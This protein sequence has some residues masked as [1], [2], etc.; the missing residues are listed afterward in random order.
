MVREL[1]VLS[2]TDQFTF[3]RTI[4]VTPNRHGGDEFSADNLL[5]ENPDNSVEFDRHFQEDLSAQQPVSKQPLGD[6]QTK[7]SSA[8]RKINQHNSSSHLS[9]HN[10]PISISD[11]WY[12]TDFQT[13]NHSLAIPEIIIPPLEN[14]DP[15]TQPK[16]HRYLDRILVAAAIGYCGF[17]GW[18]LFGSQNSIF[19]SNLLRNNQ[20]TISQADLDFLEYFEQ[21]LAVI[22]SNPNQDRNSTNNQ[23]TNKNKKEDVVYLPVYTPTPPA[24]SNH[25]NFALQP[26]SL[27]PPPP[28]PNN[29]AAFNPPVSTSPIKKPAPPTRSSAS[30]S[31][32]TSNPNNVSIASSKLPVIEN[33]PQAKVQQ[34]APPQLNQPTL[35][36]IIELKA[37]SAALF[38][39][40]GN[41]EKIWLGDKIG[42]T[43]WQLVSINNQKAKISNQKNNLVLGIGQSF[44]AAN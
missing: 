26:N 19:A 40:N 16:S 22:D 42:N 38:K 41:T 4:R 17:L 10:H 21:S 3:I 13:P 32:K 36:G 12:Q 43:G 7:D 15:V 11:H 33:T 6:R 27:L 44:E 39:V 1:S 29:F 8:L 34:L 5:S 14:S 9:I 18:S 2:A 37:N 31:K 25:N 23:A 35:V 28:P 20:P 24:Q 30:V